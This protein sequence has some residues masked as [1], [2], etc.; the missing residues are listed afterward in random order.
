MTTSQSPTTTE[1]WFARAVVSF[2]SV[3]HSVSSPVARGTGGAG[4]VPL[5]EEHPL[6][7]ARETAAP[8]DA[9]ESRASMVRSIIAKSFSTRTISR[10]AIDFRSIAADEIAADRAFLA[11]LHALVVLGE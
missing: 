8:H 5:E 4:V 1:Q 6:T 11:A 9:H 3:C 10:L 7:R 2:V